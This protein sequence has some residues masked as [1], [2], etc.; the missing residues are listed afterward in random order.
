MKVSERAEYEA[1]GRI[2]REAR[3]ELGLTQRALARQ[4]GRTETSIH[5]IEAGA[6]R[7]DMVELLDIARALRV[8]VVDLARRFSEATGVS[9]P[10]ER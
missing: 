10:S 8:S 3:E 1:L 5:K 7:V 6:Q 2:I 4:S 9:E